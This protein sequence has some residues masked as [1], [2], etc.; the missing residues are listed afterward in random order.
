MS[1]TEGARGENSW[2]TYASRITTP[3]DFAVDVAN[4]HSQEHPVG[5]RR[6]IGCCWRA[7]SCSL[8]AD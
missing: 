7:A 2:D 4:P 8:Y 1:A 6:V 5:F 3:F